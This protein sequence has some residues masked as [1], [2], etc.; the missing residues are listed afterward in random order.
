MTPDTPTSRW[1]RSVV[2]LAAV[3]LLVERML[4]GIMFT[5]T[6]TLWFRRAGDESVAYLAD[7]IGT[8]LQ[9]GMAAPGYAAFLERIVLPHPGMFTALCA[10]GELSVG[11]ALLTGFPRRLGALGGIF[12]TAN[13]GLAFGNT[14]LP[15]TGNFQITLVLLPLLTTLP[16]RWWTFRPSF[17]MSRV[18]SP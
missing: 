10:I 13:Y 12:L 14:I 18:R 2:T 15:P 6:G 16:Y 5:L 11:L 9:G 17:L 4:M 1:R 8:A 7:H 3:I